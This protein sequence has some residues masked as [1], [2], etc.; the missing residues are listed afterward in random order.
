MHDAYLN[1]PWHPCDFI[2]HLSNQVEKCRWKIS[3]LQHRQQ[4]SFRGWAL[5]F[6]AFNEWIV[7]TW[8]FLWSLW[9]LVIAC[10]CMPWLYTSLYFED[11]WRV[12]CQPGGPEQLKDQPPLEPTAGFLHGWVHWGRWWL[13][14][15]VAI[16]CIHWVWSMTL[17]DGSLMHSWMWWC[18]FHKLQQ[19]D[20]NGIPPEQFM[21]SWT[22]MNLWDLI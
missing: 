15:N 18:L 6:H 9:W 5:S 22:C 16:C 3:Q 13:F 14:H 17:S 8:I 1:I 4:V 19:M 2:W 21:W 10:H 7:F 12:T 20:A 11:L